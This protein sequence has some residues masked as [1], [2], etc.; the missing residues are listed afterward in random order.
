MVEVQLWEHPLILLVMPKV[1][2]KLF[3][4][5]DNS[6]C[7]TVL[8]GISLPLLSQ[9]SENLPGDGQ[10]ACTNVPAMPGRS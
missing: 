9:K 3:A 7:T 5:S 2:C 8:V 4:K 10:S 6:L 1:H